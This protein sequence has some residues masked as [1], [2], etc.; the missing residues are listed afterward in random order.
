MKTPPSKC[1]LNL[2]I[3]KGITKPPFGKE[4]RYADIRYQ[5]LETEDQRRGAFLPPCHCERKAAPLSA[6]Y[7]NKAHGIGSG[8]TVSEVTINEGGK[9][10][11][12]NERDLGTAR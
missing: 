3:V 11:E 5:N 7:T 2:R 8:D 6:R 4:L 1:P 10:D 9:N 12:H